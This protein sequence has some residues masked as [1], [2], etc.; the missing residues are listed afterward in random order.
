MKK[1]SRKDFIKIAGG[2]A[3]GAAAGLVFSGTPARILKELAGL[4]QDKNIIYG[5]EQLFLETVCPSCALQCQI[6]LRIADNHIIKIE[7]SNFFCPFG[8]SSVQRLSHPERILQPLRRSGEKGSGQFSPVSWEEAAASIAD[9]INQNAGTTDSIAA[10]TSQTAKARL[11]ALSTRYDGAEDECALLL[12]RLLALLG[13]PHCYSATCAEKLEL[14]ALGGVLFYELEKADLIIIFRTALFD[15]GLNPAEANR[16]LKNKNERQK[17]IYI[18]TNCNRTASIADEWIPVKPGSEAVFALGMAKYLFQTKRLYPAAVNARE[19]TAL[20]DSFDET[21]LALI[22]GIPVEK[23]NLTAEQFYSAGRAAALTGGIHSSTAELSAV[24]ALNTMIK[25]RSVSLIS[26][27]KANFRFPRNMEAYT[28][29]E[30]QKFSGLDAFI[31]NGSF[32]TLFINET[33]PVYDSVYGKELAAKMQKAFVVCLSPFI[34]ESSLH[35]DFIL[36]VLLPPEKLLLEPLQIN[37]TP[38]GDIKNSRGIT[39][40]PNENSKRGADIIRLIADKIPALNPIYFDKTFGKPAPVRNFAFK[41]ALLKEHFDALKNTN[42][43]KNYPLKLM[44]LSEALTAADGALALPYVQKTLDKNIF[45]NG[46]L[47]LHINSDTANKYNLREGNKVSLASERGASG[48]FRVH[49]TDTIAPEVAAAPLGF[50]HTEYTSFASGKGIGLRDIMN[51]DIDP[52]TGAA[53]NA[54]TRVR[55]VK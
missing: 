24:Y 3:A 45:E 54:V 5:K 4:T 42:A 35:A 46:K 29:N 27:A 55:L 11:T 43:N 52:V 16:L 22:T 6:N 47:K 7:S 30:P 51:A 53:N 50:G 23:I 15:G 31:K 20:A 13:S 14:A 1:I 8:Q 28:K 9:K 44:P 10:I 38:E 17:I 39:S 34:D 32:D 33:N 12:E 41:T 18:G 21:E 25:T 37:G 2:A 40:K 36:P 19:W 49:I 26:P 48:I